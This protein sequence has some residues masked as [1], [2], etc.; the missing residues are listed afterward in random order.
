MR[1]MVAKKDLDFWLEHNYNVLFVGEAGVGKTSMVL[2]AFDR[3]GLK[4]RY[5]SAATMDPWVDLIGVPKEVSDGDGNPVLDLIRPKEWQEDNVEAI[6]LDEYNRAPKKVRNAVMELIQ[7]KSINGKRYENLKVVWA[8]IN[9]EDSQM[10]NEYDVE[11]LDPAQ[12]DR[13]HFHVK[14]P[15][16]PNHSYFEGKYGREISGIAVEWWNSMPKATQ[17]E[18]SPRRLDYALDIYT[19]GGSLK[20]VLPKKANASKLIS[21]LSSASYLSKL[22]QLSADGDKEA[23]RKWLSDDN[24]YTNV[25]EYVWKTASNK[26]EFVPLLESE[27][28]ASVLAENPQALK[29]VKYKEAPAIKEAISGV[30]DIRK[31]KGEAAKKRLAKKINDTYDLPTAF[32]TMPYKEEELKEI[33]NQMFY[34]NTYQ[35]EKML[36]ELVANVPP[37]GE[38][39]LE[40]AK[41][42]L[43]I[44]N[45][46]CCN[47]HLATV[48]RQAN[49]VRLCNYIIK[50]LIDEGEFKIGDLRQT[51]RKKLRSLSGF[52][53]K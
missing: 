7:F 50:F 46:F 36:A 30:E 8:A 28:I 31:V 33:L 51:A 20:H 48:K 10:E 4:H 19:K 9:P 27:R 38:I 23:I 26:E 22:K 43:D 1:K 45:E 52:I 29:G 53:L 40:L 2:D 44:I 3:A 24:N 11:T 34:A 5:Y 13:F 16:K 47:S 12:K 15:Y 42:H 17:K 25:K 49:F 18:V 21:T 6:F 41:L 37:A 14:I 35:K 39:T 32:G